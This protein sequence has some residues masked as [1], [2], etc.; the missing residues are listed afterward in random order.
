MKSL[1]SGA[2]K[3]ASSRVGQSQGRSRSD[4]IRAYGGYPRALSCRGARDGAGDGD[5]PGSCGHRHARSGNPARPWADGCRDGLGL[6]CISAGIRTLRS[7]DGPVGRSGRHA[8]GSRP[9]RDLVVGADCRDGGRVQLSGH[10][11]GA[12][13]VRRR[14]GGRVALRRTYVLAMDS[15]Q[16]ART[17]ARH[18]LR[19]RSP[20]RRADAGRDRRRRPAGQW[21]AGHA[22]RDVLARRLRHLWPGWRRVGG[23]VVVPGSET[24]RQNTRR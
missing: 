23:G 8:L 4:K 12:V 6:H 9:H 18:L 17:G 15:A 16:R 24:I 13:P 2:R 21:V 10:A 5:L 3:P 22:E 14:R 1:R 11:R 19:R 20:G 7:P